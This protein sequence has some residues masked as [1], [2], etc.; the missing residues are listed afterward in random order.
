MHAMSPWLAVAVASVLRL[1]RVA[2]P[3]ELRRFSEFQYCDLELKTIRMPLGYIPSDFVFCWRYCRTCLS[4]LRAV[5]ALCQFPDFAVQ[6]TWATV[7]QDTR[8]G[9]LPWTWLV[10]FGPSL[11]RAAIASGIHRRWGLPATLTFPQIYSQDDWLALVPADVATHSRTRTCTFPN[12]S[13]RRARL[14]P[15]WS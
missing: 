14:C 1:A 3:S 6:F 2:L 10:H 7:L 4:F 12:A 9:G 8:H 5:Q 13:F 11:A 15:G